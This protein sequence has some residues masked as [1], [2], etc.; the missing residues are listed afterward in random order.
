[1]SVFKMLSREA[2]IKDRTEP[3]LESRLP[4]PENPLL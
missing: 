4:F 3:P 1:M 2:E